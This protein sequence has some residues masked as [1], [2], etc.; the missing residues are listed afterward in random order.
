[1]ILNQMSLCVTGF[2]QNVKKKKQP[3]D[4]Q[5]LIPTVTVTA[6][7]SFVVLGCTGL[8]FTS[9]ELEFCEIC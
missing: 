9:F 2:K 5:L 4:L 6:P 7:N 1:M 8:F 3:N